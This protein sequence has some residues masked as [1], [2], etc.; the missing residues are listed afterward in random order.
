MSDSSSSSLRYGKG[1]IN[2]T[3]LQC[4]GLCSLLRLDFVAQLSTVISVK[5]RLYWCMCVC[6]CVCVCVCRCRQRADWQRQVRYVSISHHS[7]LS[8]CVLYDTMLLITWPATVGK[9]YDTVPSCL[10]SGL[11]RHLSCYFH[12]SSQ[13]VGGQLNMVVIYTS[14]FHWL[15]LIGWWDAFTQYQVHCRASCEL[16]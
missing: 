3:V 15:L 8:I 9:S 14:L 5:A 10:W 2:V 12:G 6:V 16:H 13:L 7:S 4:H 11:D 1:W